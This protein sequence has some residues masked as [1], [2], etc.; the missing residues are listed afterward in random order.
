MSFYIISGQSLFDV[1]AAG[2]IYVNGE[3]ILEPKSLLQGFLCLFLAYYVY[4]YTYGEGSKKTLE[5]IQ[6]YAFYFIKQA[7]VYFETSVL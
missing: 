5:F 1:Q 4:G 6:R 2:E 3:K 7:I